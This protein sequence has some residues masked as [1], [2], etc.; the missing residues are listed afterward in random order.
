MVDVDGVVVVP[1]AGGW[2]ANLEADLGIS[3]ALLQDRFFKLH[4]NDVVLGRAGLHDR[5]AAALS[6]IAPHITSRQLAAYWF[7]KDAQLDEVLLADLAVVRAGGVQVHLAT[8]QEHERAAWLWNE[9][10]LR[11]RF[12]AMHYAADLGLRKSEPAFYAA[13]EARTG[14]A[15][16]ELL[17]LDDTPAN[18]ETAR[19]AGWQGVHW[20]GRARLA[21]L[22]T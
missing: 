12:D 11:D 15:P 14:F 10:R 7:E 9:L 18:V 16:S 8:V 21:E 13:V 1:R 5:L 3:P 6:E 22:L 19:A 17:L 20:T 2:A 4:W